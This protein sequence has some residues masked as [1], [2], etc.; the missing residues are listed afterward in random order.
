MSP[1]PCPHCGCT[2]D[3]EQ[4]PICAV[5]GASSDPAVPSRPA[6]SRRD[7]LARW[8]CAPLLALPLGLGALG[9]SLAFHAPDA[10][11]PG[12]GGVTL[13][14]GGVAAWRARYLVMRPGGLRWPRE[15]GRHPV[16]GFL[17]RFALDLAGTALVLVLILAAALA[18]F[19]ISVAGGV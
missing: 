7:R 14:L 15:P 3:P 18:G 8:G 13:L 16:F 17:W 5:C 12:F 6:Y 9:L 4:V 11:L 2:T 1:H 10:L 19:A